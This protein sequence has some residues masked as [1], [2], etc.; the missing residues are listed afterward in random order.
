[1]SSLLFNRFILRYIFF[2][3]YSSTFYFFLYQFY[4]DSVF[5]KF[6]LTARFSHSSLTLLQYFWLLIEFYL[7]TFNTP[8]TSNSYPQ[9]ISIQYHKLLIIIH[10]TYRFMQKN[11]IISTEGTMYILS[12]EEIWLY[13]RESFGAQCTLSRL[14]WITVDLCVYD[15]ILCF[16]HNILIMNWSVTF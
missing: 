7:L 9:S 2:S 11:H 1:M 13:A 6:R 10:H 16:K 8:A 5:I 12:H 3:S 4:H 15:S 14:E